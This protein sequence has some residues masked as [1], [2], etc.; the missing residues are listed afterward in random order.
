MG[1]FEI[2]PSINEIFEINEIKGRNYFSLK[3]ADLNFC[4]HP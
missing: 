1:L 3:D 4:K 2:L